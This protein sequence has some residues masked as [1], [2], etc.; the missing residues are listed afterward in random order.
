MLYFLFL[1]SYLS[2]ANAILDGEELR[3]KSLCIIGP[4]GYGKTQWAR[5]LGNHIFFTGFAATGDTIEEMETAE[6]AIFDDISG[7]FEKGFHHMKP[8]FGCNAEIRVKQLY[9]EPVLKKWGKPCIWL[10][11]HDPAEKWYDVAVGN[12]ID[13]G[14]SVQ[15]ASSN[16]DWWKENVITVQLSK[17]KGPLFDRTIATNRKK[18]LQRVARE[19]RKREEEMEEANKVARVEVVECTPSPVYSSPAWPSDV[20][21]DD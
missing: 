4:S 5:S 1:V 7:G 8:W 20:D 10:A 2:Y 15:E 19:K 18:E 9:H 11:N 17:E 12:K 6:Y 13:N 3:R 21:E 14:L 16:L